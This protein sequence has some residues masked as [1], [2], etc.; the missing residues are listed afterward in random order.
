[1]NSMSTLYLHIGFPK[2]AS[3]FLQEVVIPRVSSIDCFTKPTVR[4]GGKTERFGT[5]F[6]FSPAV[7]P[8]RGK[9]LFSQV[10]GAEPRGDAENDVLISDEGFGGG[11]TAPHPWIPA[12]RPRQDRENGP[13][14]TR[15]HLEELGTVAREWGFSR[16]RV[17]MSIRRQ[18]RKLASGYAEVSDR[19]RGASQ[20]NFERWVRRVLDPD[21]AYYEGGG[22]HHNYCLFWQQVTRAVGT[23]NV[24]VLPVE[25]LKA[26]WRAYL[27]RFF[28]F[29]EIPGEGRS[30]IRSLSQ[31]DEDLRRNVRSA[32]IDT[33]RLQPPMEMGLRPWLGRLV[34]ACWDAD[35]FPLPWPDLQREPKIR[36]TADLKALILGVYADK[37]RRLDRAIGEIDLR[38][39]GY[40][41][42]PQGHEERRQRG[43]PQTPERSYEAAP[44]ACDE[45][46]HREGL[47]SA[48]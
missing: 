27:R 7:W 12:S 6:Y 31:T 22:V 19:V 26:D 15:L 47:L 4:L 24:L 33:W 32:T 38:S 14:P 25:Q 28:A 3:S 35:R 9:E 2:T 37:N 45:R 29:L 34:R 18:D 11:V 42:A 43:R 44:T 46:T 20:K 5:R 36:L 10:L 41:P 30:I 13:Y 21:R 1:M 40:W 8:K 17:I 48:E 16:L 39:Y 23:E